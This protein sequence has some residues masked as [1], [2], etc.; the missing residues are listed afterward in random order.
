[1]AIGQTR[2]SREARGRDMGYDGG[3]DIPGLTALPSWINIPAH[4]NGPASIFTVSTTNDTGAGSLR[5][6]I[7]DANASPGLDRINFSIGSGFVVIYPKSP[8]PLITSPVIIDGT[9]Q[10]GYAGVPLIAID[11]NDIFVAADGLTLLSAAAGSTVRSLVV[12]FFPGQGIVVNANACVV[13]GC[14]VGTTANGAGGRGNSFSGIFAQDASDCRIG[15]TTPSQRN[16][17]SGNGQFGIIIR[18]LSVSDTVMGNYVGT[19]AT[20]SY[21]LRNMF[22]GVRL[23]YNSLT[24][25]GATNC[26]VGGTMPEAR[27]IISGND[28]A[29]V[30]FVGSTVTNNR[31]LGNYIGTNAAG[32]SPIGNG[33]AGVRFF[34]SATIGVSYN[35]TI[36]G[37]TAG[38]RNIISG[39]GR[40]GV[41]ILGGSSGGSGNIIIGNFIGTDAS[42]TVKLANNGYGIYLTT[43]NVTSGSITNTRVGGASSDSGNIIFGNHGVGVSL[44][45]SGVS[46]T[47]IRHNSIFG[48]DSLGIDLGA[49]RVTPNDSLD[50]DTG[51]NGLQN[52]PIIDS[53]VVTSSSTKIYGRLDAKPNQRYTVDFFT[54]DSADTWHFGEGETFF[55]EHP[56]VVCD[57]TGRVQFVEIVSVPLPANKFV[58]AIATDSLG[59]TSEFSQALSGDSDGDGI[60][61][62]WET[63]GWGIDLNS[64]GVIDYDLYAHGARPNHKDIFV[65]V[66]AMSNLGPPAGA[67]DSV[68]IAFARVNE[69]TVRNPDGQPGIALHCEPDNY[70]MAVW[71]FPLVFTNFKTVKDTA[72]GTTA[73]RS[74]PNARHVLQAKRLVYR[75]CIFANTFGTT[76]IDK[77]SSGIAEDLVC[78]DFMVTFGGPTWNNTRRW[79]D[80]A[81]TFMHEL[82][83][84]LGLDH[85]GGDG[86]SYKINYISVMN[87]IWQKDY[88]WIKSGSWSLDYSLVPLPTLNETNLDESTGLDPPA[89]AYKIIAFPFIDGLDKLHWGRLEPGV[90]ANWNGVGD[91]TETGLVVDINWRFPPQAPTR[92]QTMEGFADWSALRYNFRN[93]ASFGTG[94]MTPQAVFNELTFEMADSLDQLPPPVPGGLF[95]MDGQLDTTAI[96]ISSNGGVSLYEAWS[97]SQ[98]YVA[99]TSAQSQGGDVMIFL[100]RTRGALKAAPWLK[101]GQVGSWDAVLANESSTNVAGWLDA[102]AVLLNGLAVD[103]ASGFLE[104]V[105]DLDLYFG[106]HLSTVY[107]A[108]GRYTTEDGGALLVQVP[109]GDG[110]GNID[111]AEFYEL[112]DPALPIQ[113]ASFTATPLLNGYVRLDWVTLSEVN[114]YGFQIQRKRTTDP[115]F[116]TL[117]N[118]F[119]A[120]HGTTNEPHS[121]SFIDTMASAGQWVYR[122]K[123]IDLDGTIHYGP[124]VVVDVLTSVGEGSLPTVFALYQNFPNP[125]NPTTAIRFDVPR[126]SHVSLMVYNVLGQEL[127][128][129]VNEIRKP[130][131]YQALFN[132]SSL[133]SGVYFYKLKTDGYTG[134]KKMILTK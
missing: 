31:V 113:L 8:L 52:F 120:G 23:N 74:S 112:T 18:G 103:S 61:D 56:N 20:G 11:G 16:V 131:K 5:K 13:E 107:I 106:E 42:G 26:I 108:A 30:G 55:A 37:A 102:D 51:P 36:G 94:V 70:N 72:F 27:N 40:S 14:Y 96:L 24:G 47:L 49:N 83:H 63:Q 130:G 68:R 60:F 77:S 93:T 46:Q 2:V 41:T 45:G 3:G 117:P 134:T 44:S 65:E 80:H 109:A 33:S 95:L 111:G 104:G 105:V 90:A 76:A 85:G 58:T 38:A 87:Y 48:N 91:S 66:E 7:T 34:G 75:Y 50:S 17:L 122:L 115:D 98:L 35:N 86:I 121:Y 71:D 28:S 1:M 69:D 114:N 4:T 125:F 97:G 89:G 67:L 82:G 15:G 79:Q 25:F 133:S 128:T 119:V 132:A 22:D 57:N 78:D 126:L 81:G 84:T 127:M 39:N 32:T 73:E 123:Q 59:N 101:S 19:D 53:V 62:S 124:E 99:T 64:D 9:S 10:P 118:S 43:T 21:A 88:S 110:D 129:L 54:N 116:Q 6:A 100:A 92:D 29:G 12:S